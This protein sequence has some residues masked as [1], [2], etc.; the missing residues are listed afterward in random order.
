MT[1]YLSF[2]TFYL[3]CFGLGYSCVAFPVFSCVWSYYKKSEGRVSGLLLGA[4]GIASVF[5]VILI[6]YLSN[7]TNEP[8]D[9]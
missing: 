7:P 8:A 1:T 2:L 3:L 9:L 4:Y 5:F 6:T